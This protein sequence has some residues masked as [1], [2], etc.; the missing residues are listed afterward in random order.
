[1]FPQTVWSGG[2]SRWAH[3][4]PHCWSSGPAHHPR[5]AS[6]RAASIEGRGACP[7]LGGVSAISG[8]DLSQNKRV[9]LFYRMGPKSEYSLRWR[10]PL[11]PWRGGAPTARIIY[12]LCRASSN[13]PA[14]PVWFD[15]LYLLT[16]SAESV[17]QQ[18]QSVSLGP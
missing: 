14:L 15:K 2:P 3:W 7:M 9:P 4:R 17:G 13:W 1:M 8:G 10:S 11:C 16:A 6:P 12:I 5:N 18:N